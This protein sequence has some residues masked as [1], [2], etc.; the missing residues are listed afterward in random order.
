MRRIDVF[1]GCYRARN[2][3][4]NHEGLSDSRK[5]WPLFTLGEQKY[6]G[7]NTEPMKIHKGLRNQLCAFWNRF[8]PRLLNITDNIDEAE[9]QWKVEF[10][11]WS[12]YMM[13]WKS[14]F[15]HYS[16]QERCTDL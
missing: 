6:V 15:D 16:K 12:S 5:R 8:L 2:P 3:N 10:H 9:R 4:V 13:H 14:Q 1:T 7:L 11:R